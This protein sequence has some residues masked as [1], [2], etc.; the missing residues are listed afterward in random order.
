MWVK[1][2]VGQIKVNFLLDPR[3]ELPDG[4]GFRLPVFENG[5]R[6]F[7][8]GKTFLQGTSLVV[9]LQPRDLK[10]MRNR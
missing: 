8:I 9:G 7:V 10:C 3:T 5:R 2:R 1:G 6:R 4:D